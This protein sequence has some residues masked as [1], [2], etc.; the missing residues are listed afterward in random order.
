MCAN[1]IVSS[2][3]LDGKYSWVSVSDYNLLLSAAWTHLSLWISSNR[4]TN[5]LNGFHGRE[6]WHLTKTH[7]AWQ[8]SLWGNVPA[9]REIEL[10]W[11]C[12]HR[13][14]T[15]PPP[16]SLGCLLGLTN[17][18]FNDL[19]VFTVARCQRTS[20]SSYH[21]PS[22]PTH[23]THYPLLFPSISC[24]VWD[25]GLLKCDFICLS[26]EKMSVCCW[27][28]CSTKPF[29]IPADDWS[30]ISIKGNI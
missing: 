26:S 7:D 8:K 11:Y 6:L 10:I 12:C 2:L 19:R 3:Q 9:W 13:L 14:M 22:P 23:K 28:F 29:L 15:P 18:L 27:R 16:P 20:I 30:E 5:S 4:T 24:C 17:W 1:R 21:S 25:Q